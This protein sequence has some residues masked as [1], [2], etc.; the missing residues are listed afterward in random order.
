[1]DPQKIFESYKTLLI[2]EKYLNLRKISESLN[3]WKVWIF[4]FKFCQT[5]AVVPFFG[6]ET[7]F[8][9]KIFYIE[10][11]LATKFSILIDSHINLTKR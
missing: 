1:L 9:P 10:K 7:N 4:F 5:L 3:L 2:F 11:A 6:K 8:M